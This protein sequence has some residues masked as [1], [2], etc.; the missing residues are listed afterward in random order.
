VPE[1][2]IV[3]AS[4]LIVLARG[5]LV[6]LLRV[7][8]ERVF[9]PAAVANEISRR[10]TDDRTVQAMREA[11]WLTVVE[12]PAISDGPARYRRRSG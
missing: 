6:D 7:A 11:S 8:G 1:P 5:G 10:G 9:V 3:N 4:S 12:D 2:P